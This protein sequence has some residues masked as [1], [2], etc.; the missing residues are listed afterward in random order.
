MMRK[1]KGKTS[2]NLILE[3]IFKK[4]HSAHRV[5]IIKGLVMQI[6]KSLKVS[7][8]KDK[9]K[10][11]DKSFKSKLNKCK[12]NLRNFSANSFKIVKITKN[13][14]N[15]KRHSIKETNKNKTYK[16]KSEDMN[17]KEKQN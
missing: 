1:I 7:F 14:K 13:L 8:N 4:V 10:K 9:N 16:D 5:V 11:K 15:K 6:S 12:N 2:L 3:Q 17:N